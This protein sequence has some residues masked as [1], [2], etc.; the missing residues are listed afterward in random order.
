MKILFVIDKLGYTENIGVAYLSAIA[1]QDNHRTY[2]YSIDKSFIDRYVE[3][4]KPDV[5]AY[6]CDSFSFNKLIQVNKELKEDN[7]FVSIMGGSHP[8]FNPESFSNS[9]MDAFCVGEGEYA[10][11]DFLKCIEDGKP[12]DNVSNLITEKNI[13]PV[14]SLIKPLDSLPMP[15]HDLI[16]DNT[17]LGD[18]PK[19]TFFTSRG[20]PFN[21]SYCC[22][23]I[24]KKI[25][26]GK[27]KLVRRFSVERVIREM[28]YVKEH[29]TMDFVKLD[30]DCFCIKADDWLH[31]FVR[32]YKSRIDLPFNCVLRFDVINNKV[33]KLLKE[34]GCH[35]IHLSVDSVNPRIREKILNRNMNI[36][37]DEIIKRLKKI[38][39]FG[40]TTFVNFILGI[41]TSSIEDEIN[42]IAFSRKADVTYPSYTM[43]VPFRGTGLFD[44]C[45][46]NGFVDKDYVYGD[47]W[48][49]TTLSG[50]SWEHQLVQRNVFLLG[51]L[52]S[53]VDR[54]CLK[55]FYP[56]LHSFNEML[57]K[58]LW[59]RFYDFNMEN[60]IYEL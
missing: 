19:K 35:S 27:G 8:T 57:Y 52:L 56:L 45:M 49:W 26:A 1:K 42:T 15:D 9:R 37:N 51:A 40:I 39:T 11:K 17:M 28:E 30:D 4:V 20:C 55:F 22:N 29:Y 14:R 59:K 43:V 12:F 10:F 23:N 18:T 31:D 58:S 7:D 47:L 3:Q 24:Y 50:F 16:L 38:R 34:A 44:Y 36:D 32:E 41:P 60:V 46:L 53:K 54:E 25:Y 13:N 21:C 2:F 48:G 5:I 33:L 6:S